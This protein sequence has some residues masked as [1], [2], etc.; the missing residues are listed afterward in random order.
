M[1]VTVT[2]DIDNSPAGFPYVD[3]AYALT[4]RSDDKVLVEYDATVSEGGSEI[5]IR[6]AVWLRGA[7]K[8]TQR[9]V[10]LEECMVLPR[11]TTPRM[12]QDIVTCL[13]A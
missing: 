10:W 1:A 3:P 4:L 5:V 13:V 2:H 8:R 9:L 6:R 12:V 7:T 11:S